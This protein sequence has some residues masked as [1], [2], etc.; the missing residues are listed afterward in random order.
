M[1]IQLQNVLV[2]LMVAEW[3]ITVI[4][5]YLNVLW[6]FADGPGGAQSPTA[7]ESPMPAESAEGEDGS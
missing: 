5:P 3:L 2:F 1:N 4:W 6:V 7:E